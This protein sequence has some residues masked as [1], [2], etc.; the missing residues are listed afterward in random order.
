MVF[1]TGLPFSCPRSGSAAMAGYAVI[2]APGLVLPGFFFLL[3][4]Q[5]FDDA[6]TA[7]PHA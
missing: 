6:E 1:P 5:G 7:F 3:H 2:L 4:T